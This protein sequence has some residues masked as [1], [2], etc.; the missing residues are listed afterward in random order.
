MSLTISTLLFIVARFAGKE[1]FEKQIRSGMR[2][3]IDEM[4]CWSIGERNLEFFYQLSCC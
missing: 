1:F 2:R 4:L 3:V